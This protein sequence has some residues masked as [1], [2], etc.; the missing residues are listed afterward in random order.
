[1]EIL[2][3]NIIFICPHCDKWLKNY[4]PN[5]N[6]CIQCGEYIKN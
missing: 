3:I 2:V 5:W 1:M 6:Y 4:T